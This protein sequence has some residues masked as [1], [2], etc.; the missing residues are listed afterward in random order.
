MQCPRVDNAYGL[1][2][3][4]MGEKFGFVISEKCQL[5]NDNEVLNERT[6]K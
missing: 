5:H 4:T 2:I 3:V 6:S 1:G